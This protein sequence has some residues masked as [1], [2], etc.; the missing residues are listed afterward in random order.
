M[1]T[2]LK[3]RACHLCEAICG[4]EFEFD[5]G[6]LSRIRG[7]KA[8][9]F[10][11]GHICP[12]G[13]A[14]LDLEAD[15]DRLREPLERRG[16]S[17]RPIAWEA[18][19]ERAAENLA[20]T[21]T[22]HGASAIGAYIGNP[23]VHH[24]GTLPYAAHLLRL[25]RTPNLFSASSVDQW[26]HQQVNA[27]MYGHQFLLPIPDIDR[28]DAML[29]L[30]ANPA[31]SMG[32]LM[33]APGVVARLKSLTARGAL[34]VVDPRATETAALATQHVAVLPGG[35][36]WLLL[37]LFA[38][39]RARTPPRI[40]AYGDRLNG[41][42]RALAALAAVDLRDWTTRTGIADSEI[43]RVADTLVGVQ[44]PVV[45]GRIG[46]SIQAHGTLC[47][48]LIQ[49]LN[50]Y[51]GANDR[52]G[53][54]LPTKAAIQVTGPGT[55]RGAFGRWRSRVRGLPEF[56]GE[57]PVA[58][59][60]EEIATPG[61][62]QIRSLLS[63]CG[64]PV[65]STP[66]GRALDAA[67]PTLDHYTAIDIYRNETTRHATLILPPASP[68]KSWH[69][70]TIFNAFAVRNVTRI[71][72][73]IVPTDPHDRHDWA[74]FNALGDR[75]AA[76]LGK[77]FSPLPAPEKLIAH[78]LQHGPYALDFGALLTE[79]HGVDLGPLEPSLLD[80]LETPDRRIDCAPTALLDTLKRLTDSA[81]PSSALKLIGRRDIRSNN[82]WMHNAPR[83]IK[84]K[85][86][87]QLLMHPDDLAARGLDDGARVRVRSRVGAIETEVA[88]SVSVRLGVVSLP[89]GFGHQRD[90]VRLSAA[91]EVAGASYN[92]LSDPL[93]LDAFGN[94]AL[95][96]IDVEVEA[97]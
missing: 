74:I 35:D 72:P 64:N 38:E 26:P 62:G 34:I 87:H 94:A 54:A 29:M 32:S 55:S 89:H 60:T 58:A 43:A 10:S 30:G 5:D 86:R 25:I 81:R 6:H 44:A 48:W 41:F 56:A 85:P 1:A 97:L 42:D 83:L 77:P 69:Y 61:T 75:L 40:A 59:L 52:V 68:L 53:G 91:R 66:N 46:V 90:G 7:D 18:A 65:L 13:N 82:S 11:R 9:P 95:N 4:L 20:E 2:E 17:W 33:T 27:L 37:K 31:A 45:Y 16:D 15:P 96:G 3:Y 19:I 39:I 76:L 67:L 47:Q 93:A 23:A 50:L 51:L 70:D 79:V 49:L 57:L 80:R 22:R 71:N 28:C 14:I 36:A 92:D 73:P 12:K 88:M 84:G 8:D 78:G 24:F 63:I 21:I